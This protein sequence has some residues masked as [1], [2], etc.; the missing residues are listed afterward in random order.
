[1]KVR[2]RKLYYGIEKVSK[3]K[4]KAFRYIYNFHQNDLLGRYLIRFF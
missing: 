4:G 1:M 3:G 2:D